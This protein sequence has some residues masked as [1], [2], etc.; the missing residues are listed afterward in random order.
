MCW[1]KFD[2]KSPNVGEFIE[3]YWNSD[4]I[5]KLNWT[6]TINWGQRY[7]PRFWRYVYNN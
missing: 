4:Y 2:E 3:V 6:T 1:Y 7:K 5:E